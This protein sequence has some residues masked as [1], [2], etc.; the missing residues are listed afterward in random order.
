MTVEAEPRARRYYVIE[1]SVVCLTPHVYSLVVCTSSSSSLRP[2]ATLAANHHHQSSHGGA[3]GPP[4]PPSS[5]LP[6]PNPCT[7]NGDS[8]GP[9]APRPPPSTC[10]Y[11]MDEVE[12]GGGETRPWGVQTNRRAR[13]RAKHTV[14]RL[15]ERKRVVTRAHHW[16]AERGCGRGVK[17]RVGRRAQNEAVGC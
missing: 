6:P 14:W 10:A 17:N 1:F 9:P 12:G 2:T 5:P 8:R 7:P 13:K 4:P 11:R 15:S 3:C 16:A